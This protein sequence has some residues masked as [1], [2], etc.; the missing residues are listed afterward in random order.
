ML[1]YL[2]KIQ[3]I[4]QHGFSLSYSITE[5][6]M[7]IELLYKTPQKLGSVY[8]NGSSEQPISGSGPR[9]DLLPSLDQEVAVKK[10]AVLLGHGIGP[11]VMAKPIR[12]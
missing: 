5:F 2:D 8:D 10:V 9:L 1:F 6:Y 12:S 4:C 3:S 7:I 11:E